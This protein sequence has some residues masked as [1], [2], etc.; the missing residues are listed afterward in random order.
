MLIHGVLLFLQYIKCEIFEGYN[1]S[2]C[3]CHV[4]VI[5][6]YSRHENDK[7]LYIQ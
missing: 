5:K 4:D 2:W 7:S 1:H 3:L 6:L